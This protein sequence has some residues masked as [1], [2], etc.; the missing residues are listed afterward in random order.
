MWRI[1]AFSKIIIF[2][3]LCEHY[4]QKQVVFKPPI[5]NENNVFKQRIAHQFINIYIYE[6]VDLKFIFEFNHKKII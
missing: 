2:V 1:P 3:T 4:N 6:E 5:V